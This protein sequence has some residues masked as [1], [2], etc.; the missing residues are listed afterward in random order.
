MGL[1]VYTGYLVTVNGVA[2]PFLATTFGLDDAGISF[3]FG[4]MSL[5]AVPTLLLTRRADHWGRR[6]ILLFAC[7]VLPA[8]TLLGALAPTL[9]LYVAAQIFRGFLTGTVSTVSIVML[10]EVLPL[11]GRARGQA[12]AGAGGA[13]GGGIALLV[14]TSLSDTPGAWRWAWALG[15]IPALGL[16]LVHRVLPETEL[17]ARAAA[18]GTTAPNRMF[19][20]FERPQRRVALARLATIFLGSIPGGAAGSWVFYHIVHTLDLSAALGSAI[21]FTGGA[22]GIAGFPLGAWISDHIGRKATLVG[23]GVVASLASFA[24]YTTKGASSPLGAAG[25]GLGF[26]ALSIA[27]NA[28]L[29]AGRTLGSE[30]FPTRLRSTYY[31]WAYVAE[32]SSVIVGQFLVATLAVALGGL[33]SSILWLQLLVLPSLVIFWLYVPETVGR[34]LD[35]DD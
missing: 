14:V 28:S 12:W 33:A 8:A 10:A 18:R 17:F 20:L 24:F 9:P 32:S 34:E 29:T 6:G 21:L 25:L 31:G 26:A 11:A 16:P 3:A 35:R 2:S 4:F 19:D 22:L 1:M 27:G 13:L 30:L 5:D 7:A 15:A 23:A